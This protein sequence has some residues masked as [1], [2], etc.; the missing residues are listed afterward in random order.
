M[1]PA[2]MYW[3]RLRDLYLRATGRDATEGLAVA[4]A[5]AAGPEHL[6]D[7]F[8]LLNEASKGNTRVHFLRP[9][10]RVGGTRGREAVE[11]LRKDPVL[12]KEA[13]ALLSSR[14]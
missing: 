5:A 13:T 9:I 4:L 10:L 8:A 11:A 7:L 1:K 12:G 2:V 3:Q 6:D 14:E